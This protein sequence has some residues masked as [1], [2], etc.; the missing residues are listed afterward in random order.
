MIWA[1]ALEA[2]RSVGHGEAGLTGIREKHRG[3]HRPA[4]GQGLPA[5]VRDDKSQR[6][7]L[8]AAFKHQPLGFICKHRRTQAHQRRIIGERRL[9]TGHAMTI[10]NH[11]NGGSGADIGEVPLRPGG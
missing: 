8:N 7:V 11:R 1:K 4:G 9:Q 6:A 2:I 10:Y 5:Q 3:Q